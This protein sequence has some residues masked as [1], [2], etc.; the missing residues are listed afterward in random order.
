MIHTAR[1]T[2]QLFNTS[3]TVGRRAY[4]LTTYLD[5]ILFSR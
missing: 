5:Y 1:D 4:V 2:L 3:S